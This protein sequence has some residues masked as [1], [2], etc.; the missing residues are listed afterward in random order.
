V[1]RTAVYIATVVVVPLR[2]RLLRT[3]PFTYDVRLP[4]LQ[5]WVMVLVLL[6][7][8][9][10]WRF[11]YGSAVA[12]LPIPLKF[13]TQFIPAAVLPLLP[14]WLVGWTSGVFRHLGSAEHYH[15]TPPRQV[16]HWFPH[17]LRPSRVLVLQPVHYLP[18]VVG[19]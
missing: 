14:V 9:V 5:T 18:A 16:H 17:V 6:F 15:T 10:G 8:L 4:A 2:L 7:L 12:I 3:G 19:R 11:G 1:P 13:W